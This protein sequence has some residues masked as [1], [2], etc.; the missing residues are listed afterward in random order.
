MYT[1]QEIAQIT[2]GRL[3][4]GNPDIRISSVHFD[5]R[6]LEEGGLFVA[7]TGGARDGHDFLQDAKERGAACAL[8]SKANVDE[9]LAEMALILVENT[10]WA[11]QELAR[12]YR[13]K[14]RMP[15]IAITGSNGKTTTKDM[16]AHLLARRFKVYKTYKNLNNHLGLPLSLLQIRA[17]HE[18]A[19]LELGMNHK[20]EIDFLASIAQPNIAVLTNVGDAHLGHFG[21]RA[22]IAEAKA[23]LFAHTDKDGYIL[24][25]G[26]DPLVRNLEEKFPGKSYF[27]GFSSTN[28]IFAS[29]IETVAEGT[30]F[31][32][33]FQDEVHPFFIPTFGKHNVA[34][35]L[36]C[37]FIAKQLG[38]SFHE[39][40][41]ALK[42]LSIS[43]MR[44]QVINGPYGSMLV[45]DAYNASP[46]SM[47]ASID[48]FLE[49]Y[50]ERKKVLVLG[51][52]LELGEK[53][54]ELHEEIGRYLQNK[55]VTLF[56]IGQLAKYIS[57]KAGGTHFS[58]YEEVATALKS[59]LNEETAMLFKASRGMKLEE[60]I[61]L[62]LKEA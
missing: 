26:D 19:V 4:A 33:H 42:T 31:V 1:V 5:S 11:F 13:K 32:L 34:N 17:E 30:K 2:G 18:A 57:A 36:P 44:F 25:H 61:H 28:H 24:L 56:T 39:I 37:I 22:S 46:T 45:N 12:A 3:L 10:E 23:E 43:E 35:C 48:T 38:L 54:R 16:L 60:I 29:Q 15:I 21:S 52:I 58:S 20:G 50:P 9:D 55:K 7:L 59:H 51:D 53:E 62:L 8:I 14:L 49:I 6:Q 47:K 27:F 40:K 41:E